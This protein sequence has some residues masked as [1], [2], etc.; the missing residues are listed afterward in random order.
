M[1]RRHAIALLAA[2]I[3][4]GCSSTPRERI[5]TKEVK[6]PVSVPCLDESDVPPTQAYEGDAVDFEAANI[7][8]LVQVL[9]VEREQRKA[10]EARLRAP[11]SSCIR[12]PDS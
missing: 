2:L 7:F 9:L 6:I 3:L 4:G 10:V 5:V 11:L 1:I 8:E 12:L